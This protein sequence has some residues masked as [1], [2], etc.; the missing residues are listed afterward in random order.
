M[1]FHNKRDTRANSTELVK[2]LVPKTIITYELER[3][4]KYRLGLSLSILQILENN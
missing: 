1:T 3:S 2:V 4:N